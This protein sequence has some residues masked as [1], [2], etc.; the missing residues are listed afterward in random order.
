MNALKRF[1]T[2]R[3]TKRLLPWLSAVVLLAGVGAV[4]GVYFSNTA[5]PE[6]GLSGTPVKIRNEPTKQVPLPE[7]ARKVA[8]R[9]I[10]TAVPRRHLAE[11]YKLAHPKLRQG[12]TLKQW[13]TGSIPVAYYPVGTN[14]DAAT[15][16]V[17]YSHP[18]DAQLEL[19]LVPRKNI[20]EAPQQ[21]LMGLQKFHRHWVV[22]YWNVLGG[23]GVPNS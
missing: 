18:A 15:F 22:D 5:K 13:E 11:S 1:A 14:L 20:N 2:S 21:F 12:L 9:L 3:R 19:S 17:D 8:T 10:L 7:A 16:K 4:L 6:P 23:P